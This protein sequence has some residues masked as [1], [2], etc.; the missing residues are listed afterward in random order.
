MAWSGLALVVIYKATNVM[1]FAQGEMAMF[2]T[3]IAFVLITDVGLP[4]IVAVL[5]TLIISRR[6]PEPRWN[7]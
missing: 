6:S 7:G 1:N 3:F 2:S 5:L 4:Y